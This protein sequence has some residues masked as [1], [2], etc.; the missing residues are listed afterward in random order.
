M[1]DK[2]MTKTFDKIGGLYALNNIETTATKNKHTNIKK[3]TQ[4]TWCLN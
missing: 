2:L 3:I 4:N 1:P